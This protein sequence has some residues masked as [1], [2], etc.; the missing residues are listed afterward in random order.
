MK[1]SGPL[2]RDHEYFRNYCL[3]A[4]Y[5]IAVGILEGRED[6]CLKGVRSATKSFGWGI[7]PV[8]CLVCGVIFVSTVP[9][10]YETQTA[11]ESNLPQFLPQRQQNWG[12]RNLG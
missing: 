10:A 8:L 2:P 7:F 5:R 6:A 4:A 9:L 3:Y 11:P 1:K 12:R